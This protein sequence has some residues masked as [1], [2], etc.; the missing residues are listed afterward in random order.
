MIDIIVALASALG[1]VYEV[2]ADGSIRASDLLGMLAGCGAV[3][4]TNA[5]V[6]A[7]FEAVA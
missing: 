1:G 3:Q 2:L 6:S 7:A 5:C 4:D